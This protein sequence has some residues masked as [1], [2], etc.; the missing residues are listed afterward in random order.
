MNG[1]ALTIEHFVGHLIEHF[2]DLRRFMRFFR[3][4][5]LHRLPP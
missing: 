5:N 1:L 4:P 2:V 3:N